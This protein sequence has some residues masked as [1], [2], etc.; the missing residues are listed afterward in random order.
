MQ[1]AAY[2]QAEQRLWQRHERAPQEQWVELAQPRARLRLQVI[3]DGPP[4]LFL[5]GGPGAGSIFASV[6]AQLPDFRCLLLDR[7]GSGLSP[8]LRLRRRDR[9][10]EAMAALLKNLLDALGLQQVRLV[11]SSF[12]G[13]CALWFA[14]RHRER[15]QS[16][17]HLGCPAFLP[18]VPVMPLRRLLE[19]PLFGLSLAPAPASRNGVLRALQALGEQEALRQQRIPEAFI[20][21]WLSLV[22]DTPTLRH[23]RSLLGRGLRGT[24][25]R[26]DYLL[27]HE[28]LRTLEI[29]LYVYWGTSDPMAS[30]SYAHAWVNGL[31]QGRLDLLHGSGHLPWLDDPGDAAARLRQ[32]FRGATHWSDSLPQVPPPLLRGGSV[33]H[34]ARG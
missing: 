33:H 8:R 14:L 2:R 34:G 19:T 29:P 30:V 23:E 16:I 20:E 15:V 10:D 1:E 11:T 5:H 13:S 6:A 27:D 12:G 3:G 32:F 4:L 17:A 28:R 21:W 26:P 22:R 18:G 31:R 9:L 7:P 25:V 24:A